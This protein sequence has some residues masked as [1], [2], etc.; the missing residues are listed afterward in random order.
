MSTGN[1]GILNPECGILQTVMIYNKYNVEWTLGSGFRC[2]VRDELGQKIR[3]QP[4]P[5]ENVEK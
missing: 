3:V 1:R 4:M 2:K 5:R